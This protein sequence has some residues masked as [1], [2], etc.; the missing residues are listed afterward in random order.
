MTEHEPKIPR[1]RT[2]GAEGGQKGK[3]EFLFVQGTKA[4]S[5]QVTM[6]VEI[7]SVSWCIS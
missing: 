6:A 5:S 1:V 3:K 4:S 2:A 7:L